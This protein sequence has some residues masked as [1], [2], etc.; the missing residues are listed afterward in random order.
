MAD[1][2]ILNDKIYNLIDNDLPCLVVYSEKAGGSHFTVTMITDLFLQGKKILFLTAYPMAKDNFLE[3][4]KDFFGKTIYI[5]DKKQLDDTPGIIIES[6][7]EELFLEAL[8]L[9]PDI[10]ERIILIKNMEVFSQTVFDACLD[11]PNLI[12]SGDIDKCVAKE[13][14]IKKVYKTIVVFSKPQIKLGF[15]IPALEKYV[16][17]WWNQDNKGLVKI[18]MGE[19]KIN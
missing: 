16:G 15:E 17:Y 6:G 7:N 4:I 9:L 3:Q 8:K 14:I 18:K 13:Q 11:F 10:K 19:R 2:I 5:T 1:N 12:L